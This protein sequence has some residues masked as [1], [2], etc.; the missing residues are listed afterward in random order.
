M[1]SSKPY[2]IRAI[3]EWLVD[4]K[5]TPYLAVD[6]S[7]EGVIVPEEYIN[8]GQIV[9]NISPK[10]V[11]SLII[12]NDVT[13]FSA[14]FNAVVHKI[15]IP[16]AAV[17]AIYSKENNQGMVFDPE[18]YNYDQDYYENTDSKTKIKLQLLDG[19]KE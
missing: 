19:G 11:K 8:N 3:Y 2:L 17:T 18:E 15:Y 5:F 6:A 4:N 7:I 14:C 16:I 10:S 12:G 9:L 1:S 13:E